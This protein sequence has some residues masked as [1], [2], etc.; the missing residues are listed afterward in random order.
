[1]ARQLE[2][3]AGRAADPAA[4]IAA[5]STLN[6]AVERTIQERRAAET[7]AAQ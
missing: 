5:L 1:M 6:D 4:L 2:L 3:V 7:A